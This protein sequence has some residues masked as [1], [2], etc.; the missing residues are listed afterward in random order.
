MIVYAI[1]L[2]LSILLAYIAIK[3]KEIKKI[4][5]IF[6]ILSSL[7]FIVVSAI[8][9][10]V[11]NDFLD[12]YSQAFTHIANGGYVTTYEYAF[13]LL[14]KICAFITSNPQII[15]IVTSIIIN[16][17]IFYL[18]FKY[19]KNPIFSIIIFFFG[20]FFFESM[21]GVRQYLAMSIMLLAL[22]LVKE[23]KYIKTIVLIIL[24][25]FIHNISIILGFIYV[26]L[27]I[28]NRVY[29]KSII[30]NKSNNI[31]IVLSIV[32]GIILFH[33]FIYQRITFLL[34][35]I[36]DKYYAYVGSKYDY[37]DLQKTPLLVSLSVYF[38]IYY[39]KIKILKKCKEKN[40]E[41]EEK[42]YDDY[43]IIMQTCAL[44]FVAMTSMNI[45]FL[46]I[47]YMFSIFEIFSIPY[48]YEKYYKQNKKNILL[49]SVL[50]TMLG[51]F[52]WINVIHK[53]EK[54]LPYK[55]VFSITKRE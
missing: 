53:V 20:A 46:R 27:L 48:Y 55:T 9:Y 41:Y 18:I 49:Y 39:A 16:S 30:L 52:I 4:Y 12:R 40:I 25:Y 51:A 31:I 26:A 21:N 33:R 36:S 34:S 47:S 54:A 37:S 43:F 3:Y 22:P 2:I 7:P 15:F 28:Y 5:Y 44:I 29:P 35:L 23:N 38:Y 32:I 17:I 45:L 50:L 42:S 6:T 14:N 11:G 24:S 13:Y 10:D 8:R 19:S 1:M